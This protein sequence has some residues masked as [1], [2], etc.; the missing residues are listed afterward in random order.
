MFFSLAFQGRFGTVKRTC[1]SFTLSVIL[2]VIEHVLKHI[3]C[4]CVL[5]LRQM[6]ICGPDT[7]IINTIVTMYTRAAEVLKYWGGAI[8]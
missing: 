5:G 6:T 7:C 4:Q 2:L 3:K 8:Y 1:V